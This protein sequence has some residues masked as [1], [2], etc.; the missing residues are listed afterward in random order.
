MNSE[1]E[2][3]LHQIAPKN[4]KVFIH[5]YIDKGKNDS[6]LTPIYGEFWVKDSNVFT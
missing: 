3:Q 4:P 6:E 5:P 1:G 2:V